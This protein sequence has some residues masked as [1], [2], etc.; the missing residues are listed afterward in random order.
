[1]Q[2]Q[3]QINQLS[4]TRAKSKSLKTRLA[5]WVSGD[6]REFKVMIK[7]KIS[8][9]SYVMMDLSASD[10]FELYNELYDPSSRVLLTH[11]TP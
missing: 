3:S 1:M 9:P 2:S 11:Y 10:M 4:V 5:S 8:K 6:W 7:N